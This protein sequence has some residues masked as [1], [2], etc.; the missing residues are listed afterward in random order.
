MSSCLLIANYKIESRR[1]TGNGGYV[2]ALKLE[3]DPMEELYKTILLV[4]FE[5]N[6]SKLGVQSPSEGS[7]VVTLPIRD[8]HDMY[9]ILQTEAPVFADWLADDENDLKSFS[10]RTHEEPLGE[11]PADIDFIPLS[12]KK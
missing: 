4:F 11:G 6:L 1:T 10:L 2:R 9:H 7:V 12:S 3:L 5:E 8:F